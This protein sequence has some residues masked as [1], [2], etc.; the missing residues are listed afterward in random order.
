MH[1]SYQIF[2][3]INKTDHVRWFLRAGARTGVRWMAVR[4]V[5]SEAVI[6]RS[7]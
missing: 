7:A 6:Y 2:F 1:L 3:E 4:L 5:N